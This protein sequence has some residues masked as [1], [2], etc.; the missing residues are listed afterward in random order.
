[1]S[2]K[3]IHHF[4]SKQ[5]TIDERMEAGKALRKKFPSVNQ[6]DYKISSI[7]AEQHCQN[8]VFRVLLK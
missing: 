7:R 1:M 5:L 4:Q 6:G 3:L 2:K 8:L